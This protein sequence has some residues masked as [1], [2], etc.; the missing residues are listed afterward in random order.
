MVPTRLRCVAHRHRRYRGVAIIYGAIIMTVLLGVCV[1]TVDY[2]RAQLVRMELQSCADGAVRAAA[3]GIP[4]S[5][6]EARKRGRDVAALSKAGGAA[7]TIP[8][9]DFL[10]GRWND[11]TNQIDAATGTAVNAVQVTTRRTVL[12]A[13][14][15]SINKTTSDVLARATAKVTVASVTGFIGLSA[16]TVRQNAFLGS[17][18][19]L[20]NPTPSR[21]TAGDDATVGSNGVL[22]V[23]NNADING[24]VF[25]G[26]SGS[27]AG[28][29]PPQ[30]LTSAIPT[31]AL[32]TM[33]G[34]PNPGGVS[35]ALSVSGTVTL[36][37]GTYVLTSLTMSKNATLKFSGA[38]VIKLNG[39]LATGNNATIESYSKLPSN[40]AIYQSG[41]YDFG[42]DANGV[43]ITA[44]I[45][46]PGNRLNFKNNFTLRGNG[47]FGTI[48]VKNN[49]EFYFDESL[50]T[51]PAGSA[52][53]TTVK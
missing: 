29:P 28:N 39:A 47:T 1:L 53:L 27:Y 5:L 7:I 34:G 20:T 15:P 45:T 36:P 46:A 26:P 32:P 8:D 25:I 41:S 9:G 16:F 51:A 2:G 42:D 21:G 17:Y 22:S 14:G 23:G 6:A 52:M 30:R 4:T 19:P 38:A 13:F 11:T 43:T 33:T 44:V 10:F 49:A 3:S 37:G 18:N 31:P 40:L 48:D 50:G 35:A 12:L 24:S